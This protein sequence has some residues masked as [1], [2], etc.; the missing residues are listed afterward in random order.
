MFICMLLCHS[1]SYDFWILTLIFHLFS[2][3][4]MPDALAMII[5]ERI[6]TQCSN[7]KQHHTY[8]PYILRTWKRTYI[9][10]THMRVRRTFHPRFWRGRGNNGLGG[11]TSFVPSGEQARAR[12]GAIGMK[13][14]SSS[15]SLSPDITL[16]PHELEDLAREVLL[17]RPIPLAPG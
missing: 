3:N 14:S 11:Q 17:V 6:Y 9:Q 4:R 1:V 12:R 15:L 7:T 13:S 2:A 5:V 10:T 16:G 8:T